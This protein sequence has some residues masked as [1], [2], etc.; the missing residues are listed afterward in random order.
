MSS[1]SLES[2]E[3]FLMTYELR[4]DAKNR[5]LL[6]ES[7][8]S[9]AQANVARTKTN[10]STMNN[11]NAPVVCQICDK[12]YHIAPDCYQASQNRS[13]TISA[14]SICLCCKPSFELHI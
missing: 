3:N 11:N 12:S 13:S 6:T 8:V 14:A 4:L 9:V 7:Q 5:S 10:R 2:F 1:F